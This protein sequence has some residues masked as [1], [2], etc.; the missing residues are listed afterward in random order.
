MKR[1]SSIRKKILLYIL[2][3]FIVF[4]LVS[5]GYI[6]I[7][8]RK[9]ILNETRE[10]T[11]LL[12][13]NY[14]AEISRLFEKNITIT[15]TLS[16]AFTTYKQMPE[17]QWASLFRDMYSPVIKANPDIYL[18][19]D[20]WEYYGFKPNYTKGYGRSLMYILRKDDGSFERAIE[21]R[22]MDGDPSTY[23]GFKQLNADD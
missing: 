9:T 2:S 11:E 12:A 3:V 5:I 1:K 14:A 10:K 4:Y 13:A 15:R 21:E 19:W 6:T 18:V 20:S 23:G 7:N 22:S 8:A 16:Q 17:E